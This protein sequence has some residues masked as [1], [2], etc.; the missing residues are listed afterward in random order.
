MP[1]LQLYILTTLF[2]L[3]AAGPIAFYSFLFF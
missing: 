3:I 1:D 2:G